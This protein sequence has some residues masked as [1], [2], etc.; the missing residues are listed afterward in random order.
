MIG[1]LL[2]LLVAAPLPGVVGMYIAVACLAGLDTVC[3]GIRSSLEGKFDGGIFMTGFF[4]NMVIA[5]FLAWLGD[6]IG[7]NL[8]LASVLILGGRIFVNLS[9][10]RRYLVNRWRESRERDKERKAQAQQ[11]AQQAA[12]KAPTSP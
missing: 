3:G 12:A 11:Q 8:F 9:L 4:S 5:F 7:I 10:I 1:V 2:G 6:R